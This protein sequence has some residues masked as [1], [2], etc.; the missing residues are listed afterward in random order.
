MKRA[1]AEP[2]PAVKR[3]ID[4]FHAAFLARFGFKP[5]IHGGKDGTHFRQML[6]TWDEEIVQ[7]LIAEFFRTTDPRALRSDYTVGALFS[8]AQHLLL[9]KNG[10]TTDQRTAE[11]MDT[12]SRATQR[13]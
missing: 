3:A 7:W 11:I 6:A 13:R 2:N 10:H 9:R 4:A 5:A 12:A 1:K 8:L